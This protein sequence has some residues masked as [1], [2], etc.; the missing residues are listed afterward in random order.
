M[1]A[2]PKMY[3]LRFNALGVVHSGPVSAG[4]QGEPLVTLAPGQTLKFHV[5]TSKDRGVSLISAAASWPGN[6]CGPYS[7]DRIGVLGDTSLRNDGVWFRPPQAGIVAPLQAEGTFT[8]DGILTLLSGNKSIRV[9]LAHASNLD[10]KG[11]M[12]EDAMH[13]LV[14]KPDKGSVAKL[15]FVGNDLK[16]VTIG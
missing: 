3:F 6:R 14:I 2:K 10:G 12:V 7:T 9:D 13:Y 1:A 5:E 15:R 11:G 8:S 16:T 4:N